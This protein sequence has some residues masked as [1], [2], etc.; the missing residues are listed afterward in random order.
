MGNWNWDVELNV[1]QE[2]GVGVRGLAAAMIWRAC[3]DILGAKVSG[4]KVRQDEF[5]RRDASAWLSDVVC[6]DVCS[7]NWCCVVLG[8]SSRKLRRR[9]FL[10]I[11]E[12][13]G[14]W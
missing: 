14:T 11:R 2:L 6:D 10:I 1:E 7:F 9:I 13:G 5:Y 3:K 4:C 8:V 12:L